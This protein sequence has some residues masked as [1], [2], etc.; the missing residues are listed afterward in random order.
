MHS[1][2]CPATTIRPSRNAT[3]HDANPPP[4]VL[5]PTPSLYTPRDNTLSR[6]SISSYRAETC[7]FKTL[8]GTDALRGIAP[9]AFWVHVDDRLGYPSDGPSAQPSP[10]HEEKEGGSGVADQAAID[11]LRKSSFMMITG[12]QKSTQD[13]ARV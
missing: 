9:H 3:F 8:A 10:Q 4:H 12:C 13:A 11:E 2:Q 5:V 6:T 7:F 1:T